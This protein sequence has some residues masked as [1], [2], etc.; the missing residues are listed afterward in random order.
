MNIK[1]E[2]TNKELSANAGLILFNSLFEK[3][4]LGS[5]LADSVPTLK[6]GAAR[7][8]R[9]L[10]QLVLG[11]AA[12][13]ECLDDF[14]KLAADKGFEAICDGHVYSSKACGDFLR[15]FSPV[16]C[17]ALN[18]H[19]ISQAYQIRKAVAGKKIHHY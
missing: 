19:L 3:T 6:N 10:K 13:A 9:K 12:G 4:K 18:H 16:N 17:K 7:S 8:I 15:D 14:D 2:S 5:C 1:I 11:L